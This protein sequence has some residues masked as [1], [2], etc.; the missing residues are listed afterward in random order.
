VRF[1]ARCSG[2]VIPVLSPAG[3]IQGAQIR[4]DRPFDGRKYIWF[5]SAELKHG[6]S[7]GSPVHFAGPIGKTLYLT[8]GGLKGAV[9]HCLS[10]HSFACIAGAGLY[11]NFT[12]YFPMLREHGVEEI[13]VAYDMDLLTN[14]MVRQ[15]CEH[16]LQAARE[17]G[18]RVEQMHWDPVNKGID[19][20]YLAQARGTRPV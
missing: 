20:H 10:G 16:I 5:P 6:I 4:L 3:Q 8:E 15:A 14:D 19:D 7:S 18:F 13:V 1:H 9:A 12:R 2:V 11:A 17:A